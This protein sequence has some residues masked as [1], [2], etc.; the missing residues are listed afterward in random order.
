MD[1]E[2]NSNDPCSSNDNADSS[3]DNTKSSNGN[4]NDN[5]N[6]KD[7]SDDGSHD[8]SRVA[9]I[10]SGWMVDFCFSEACRHFREGDA[11]RL[12]QTLTILEGN[13]RQTALGVSP[14]SHATP[15]V[16]RFVVLYIKKS[17]FDLLLLLVFRRSRFSG[18][19]AE[20]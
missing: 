5:G 19:H 3:N 7:F 17:C 8:F 12:N 1:A 15:H 2:S 4:D 13:Y 11:E 20:K 6:S 14:L 16:M 9:S 18:F 10:A